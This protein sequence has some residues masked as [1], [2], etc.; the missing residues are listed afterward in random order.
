MQT[1]STNAAEIPT[2]LPDIEADEDR[3]NL[4]LENQPDEPQ[5]EEVDSDEL[6]PDVVSNTEAREP[7]KY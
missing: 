6:A 2:A 7:E 5:D 1:L 3:E 4:L